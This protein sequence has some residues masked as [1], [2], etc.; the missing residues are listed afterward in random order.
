MQI[1]P[2]LGF[3]T[4]TMEGLIVRHDVPVAGEAK[5]V[6]RTVC[7]RED[8]AMGSCTSRNRNG[9]ELH[10]QQVLEATATRPVISN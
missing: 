9:E 1:F 3:C 8:E 4:P 5:E 6:E 7:W 2:G 10:H